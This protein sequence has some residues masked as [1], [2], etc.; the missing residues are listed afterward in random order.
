MADYRR[1][2]KGAILLNP[3]LGQ[4]LTLLV[5][6]PYLA[7]VF[8]LYIGGLFIYA[9]MSKINY[10]AEFAESI[11]NYQLVPFWAVNLMAVTLPWA[12][13][14]CGLLLIIGVRA[15]AG[16]ASLAALLVIFSAA[17]SVSLLRGTPFGCGCFSSVD[18]PMQWTTV[19]L[20]LLW[21]GMALHVYFFD[22]AF[23]LEKSF[24]M[25]I[26]DIEP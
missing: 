4:T 17:I 22:S 15:K 12:E 23:H 24:T 25:A 9:S 3:S 10:A 2:K 14:L 1:G 13:L 21:L 20:D 11:A 19:L 16:A 26:K 6:H 18:Q 7:L 5:R 8:R